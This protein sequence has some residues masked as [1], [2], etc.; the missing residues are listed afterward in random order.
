MTVVC[1][2]TLKPED[3]KSETNNIY[4]NNW[5][6]CTSFQTSNFHLCTELFDMGFLSRIKINFKINCSY[7]MMSSLS[8]FGKII[9]DVQY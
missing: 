3:I 5:T 2:V 7:S 8:N 1:E 6:Y 9:F 4:E